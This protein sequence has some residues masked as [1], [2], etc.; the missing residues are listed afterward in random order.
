MHV[1]QSWHRALHPSQSQTQV[2]VGEDVQRGS[3][4]RHHQLQL[5][6]SARKIHLDSNQAPYISLV[7]TASN[8]VHD[9]T[10]RRNHTLLGVPEPCCTAK[11]LYLIHFDPAKRCVPK[12]LDSIMGYVTF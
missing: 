3:D 10:T 2:I 5:S 8:L 4:A 7:D 11:L 1:C 12:P 9:Q 6:V